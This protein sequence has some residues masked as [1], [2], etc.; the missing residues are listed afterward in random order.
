MCGVQTDLFGVVGTLFV[1]LFEKYMT[2]FMKGSH[3]WAANSSIK[4]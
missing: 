2:V 1:L 4:R 3:E